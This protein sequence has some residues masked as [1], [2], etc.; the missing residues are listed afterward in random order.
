MGIRS[1]AVGSWFTPITGAGLCTITRQGLQVA[2]GLIHSGQQLKIEILEPTMLGK[3]T[4]EP[5]QNPFPLQES[6]S[7]EPPPPCQGK[8]F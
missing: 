2:K 8:T 4:T 7:R 1:V 5:F 3:R 6:G